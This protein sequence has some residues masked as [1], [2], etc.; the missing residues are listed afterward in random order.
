MNDVNALGEANGG[1]GWLCHEKLSLDLQRLVEEL[2][3]VL[4]D[5]HIIHD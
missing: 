5:R 4:K 3:E 1:G 2:L